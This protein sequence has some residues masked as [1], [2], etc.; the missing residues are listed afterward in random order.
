MLI[1]LLMT[2]NLLGYQVRSSE[3]GLAWWDGRRRWSSSH[4]PRPDTATSGLVCDDIVISVFCEMA[5]PGRSPQGAKK[6]AA[7]KWAKGWKKKLLEISCYDFVW[8]FWGW[9]AR[10][11][12]IIWPLL[13]C[14]DSFLKLAF[15]RKI[16][17]TRKNCS[18]FAMKNEERSCK[19]LGLVINNPLMRKRDSNF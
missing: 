2:W 7:S 9:T 13:K 16:W 19:T 11:L 4:L 18:C 15:E 5:V 14:V 1:R 3:I 6:W 10:M 8:H 12:R 17:E